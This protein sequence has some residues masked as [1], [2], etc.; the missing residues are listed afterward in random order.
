MEDSLSMYK[1]KYMEKHEDYDSLK[2]LHL[3]RETRVEAFKIEFEEEKKVN[4]RLRR[5]VKQD[6]IYR[7]A[8]VGAAWFTIIGLTMW[9]MVLAGSN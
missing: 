4:D 7:T 6:D 1:F 5:Y 3:Q 2:N 8:S 9:F